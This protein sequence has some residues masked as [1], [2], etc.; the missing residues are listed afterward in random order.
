VFAVGDQAFKEKASK[1]IRKKIKSDYTVVLVTHSM[2]MVRELCDRVIQIE[3]GRLLP[4]LSVD[5]TV[6]RYLI[7]REKDNFAK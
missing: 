3:D 7:S 4:E 2:A 6:E 5:Q 1:L